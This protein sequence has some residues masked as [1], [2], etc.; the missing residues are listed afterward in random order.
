L[1]FK[2]SIYFFL[3]QLTKERF[4][5]FTVSSIVSSEVIFSYGLN[6]EI[7]ESKEVSENETQWA[8]IS[9]EEGIED[10]FKIVCKK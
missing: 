5:S 8:F 6:N 9:P 4:S 2:I 3:V 10:I 7:I 1:T